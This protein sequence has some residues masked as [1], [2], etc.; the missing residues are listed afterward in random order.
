[1]GRVQGVNGLQQ[2]R[3]LIDNLPARAIPR[4]SQ[5]RRQAIYPLSFG[6]RYLSMGAVGHITKLIERED[7][8]RQRA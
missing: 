8:E 7:R 2:A 6:G 3:G 5:R 1:M 4:R